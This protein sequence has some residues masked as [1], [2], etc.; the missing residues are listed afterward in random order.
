MIHE[1]NL[2]TAGDASRPGAA[3]V[4]E[5]DGRPVTWGDVKE[6]VIAAGKGAVEVDPLA[7]E[8]DARRML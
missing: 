8:R 3:V 1:Q 6:I 2:A 7:M 4:A 5:I